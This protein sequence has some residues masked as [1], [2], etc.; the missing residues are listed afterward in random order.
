MK[1]TFQLFVEPKPQTRYLVDI[2][3][4]Y[5]NTRYWKVAYR[6]HKASSF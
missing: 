5:T 1:H 6:D 4:K 2:H 3:G